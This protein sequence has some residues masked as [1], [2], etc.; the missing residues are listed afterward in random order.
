MRFYFLD[1]SAVVKRYTVEDGSV[2]VHRLFADPS[3]VLYASRLARIETLC[4]LARKKRE[5]HLPA[6]DFVEI[7]Q[8][9][10]YEWEFRLRS[11]ECH[12]AGLGARC[13]AR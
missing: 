7:R 5:G 4:A 1:S 13:V 10:L 2:F 11:A 9:F 6:Q 3:A 8:Q 12:G